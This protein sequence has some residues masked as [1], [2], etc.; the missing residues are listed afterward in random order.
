MK[1]ICAL[2]LTLLKICLYQ[3]CPSINST[4]AVCCGCLPLTCMSMVR[5]KLFDPPGWLAAVLRSAVFGKKQLFK[6]GLDETAAN[7][8]LSH[9]LLSSVAIVAY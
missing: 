6:H 5:K 2:N 4:T 7:A 9:T 1:L 3:N 8:M